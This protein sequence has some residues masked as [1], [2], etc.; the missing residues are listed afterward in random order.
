MNDLKRM[1]LLAVV[2]TG[3][4]GSA[5]AFAACIEGDE[6][7]VVRT[8]TAAD[9]ILEGCDGE[10][11][12]A[13]EGGRD[14]IYGR[15]RNDTLAGG[16]GNDKIFGGPGNDLLGGGDGEDEL[17]GEG[18]QDRFDGGPGTLD[19]V[20]FL[21]AHRLGVEASVDVAHEIPTQ[22]AVASLRTRNIWNDGFGNSELMTS[23]EG[24]GLGTPHADQFEG[25]N[26]MNF[27]EGV[28][29]G[30]VVFGGRGYDVFKVL[31]APALINGGS[32]KNS[33]NFWGYRYVILG[34]QVVLEWGPT[35]VEV[36][37]AAE[38]LRDG[39]GGSGVIRNCLDLQG[40][41][42]DDRL[43]G[44]QHSN[45]ID[46][47][48]GD[49][50]IDGRGGDDWLNGDQGADILVGGAGADHFQYYGI[51]SSLVSAVDRI[52]DFSQSQGDRISLWAIDADPATPAKDAFA[53]VAVETMD[54]VA[55]SVTFYRKPTENETIVHVSTTVGWRM[56]IRL[57]GLIVLRAADFV[58][59]SE[60]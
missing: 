10:D 42:Q 60:P 16:G 49:D 8:G 34:G 23:I 27:F 57:R 17:F 38:K 41:P 56:A 47:G 40:T 19:W 35:G 43:Y 36:D 51:T 3:A 52:F 33:C 18:G 39:W 50:A 28:G 45:T 58:F 22:G 31:D 26:G 2:S 20:A 13:G 21:A 32:G 11:V 55:G 37:L 6:T 4:L 44:E 9:E 29:A 46:G 7:P 1:V 24:F 53:F 54:F 5:G 30:D 15:G 12:L 59:E 48:P 25:D 14:Q